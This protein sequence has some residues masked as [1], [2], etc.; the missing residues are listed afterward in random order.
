MQ[1]YSKYNKNCFFSLIS[2]PIFILFVL[3]DRAK[4][5]LLNLY[6][7]FWNSLIMLI[8]AN[9]RSPGRDPGVQSA[10]IFFFFSFIFFFFHVPSGASNLYFSHSNFFFLSLPGHQIFIFWPVDCTT[11]NLRYLMMPDERYVIDVLVRCKNTENGKSNLAALRRVLRSIFQWNRYHGLPQKKCVMIHWLAIFT[12]SFDELKRK[13][14]LGGGGGEGAITLVPTHFSSL[15]PYQSCYP[16][17]NPALRAT[18][19]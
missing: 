9:L 15:Y 16:L 10:I 17:I 14:L 18:N 4:W 5:R 19:R 11:W 1:I 6:T 2:W 13:F 3:S 8:Y 7:K 12:T